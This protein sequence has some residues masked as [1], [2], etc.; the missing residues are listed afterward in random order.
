MYNNL[1]N[2]I[3][4]ICDPT[5]NYKIATN[6]NSLLKKYK[7]YDKYA[8]IYPI[9]LIRFRYQKAKKGRFNDL[10]YKNSSIKS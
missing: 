10:I 4:G 5:T 6:P 9:V 3:K 2:N 7:K 8:S 1:N